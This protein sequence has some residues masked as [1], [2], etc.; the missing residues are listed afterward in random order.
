[1]TASV[2]LASCM[3]GMDA[4]SCSNNGSVI[5]IDEH[6]NNKRGVFMVWWGGIFNPKLISVGENLNPNQNQ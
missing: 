5:M 3:M 6:V 2:F 1:M 4:C